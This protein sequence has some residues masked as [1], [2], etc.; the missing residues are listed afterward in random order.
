MKKLKYFF[1]SKYLKLLRKA[2]FFIF[3]I[4]CLDYLIGNTLKAYYFRS[5]TG[6]NYQTTYSMDSTTAD[7]LIIGSSRANHHYIP[8]IFEDSLNM[9][10]FNTGRDGQFLLFSYAIFCSAVNRYNPKIILFDINP[11][12]LYTDKDDFERLS[13]LFPYYK[14]KPELRSIIEL[15]GPLERYKLKSSIY[16]FNSRILSI[17]NGNVSLID[18]KNKELKGYAP[19]V[20]HL[21]DSTMIRN[22]ENPRP[23]SPIASELLNTICQTCNIRNIRLIMIQSPIY[24]FI[25]VGSSTE[26][27]QELARQFNFELWSY[28]NDTSYLKSNYFKDRSH[29]NDLGA[30]KFSKDIA[31]R[32][33]R[34]RV[35]NAVV[36]KETSTRNL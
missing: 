15:K 2:T 17:I 28:F 21:S 30:H 35:K 18:L 34:E 22:E 9:S 19:L 6:S 7:I 11:S 23:V 4:I 1:I 29:L 8:E 26:F 27:Y 24:E 33:K 12:D 10:C 5:T 14:G 32:L 20:G 25:E 31:S 3:L 36:S 13:N 16:P